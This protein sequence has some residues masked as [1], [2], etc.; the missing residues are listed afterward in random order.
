MKIKSCADCGRKPQEG[1]M[2]VL[3]LDP[4]SEWWLTLF[5][6]PH[7]CLDCADKIGKKEVKTK[8]GLEG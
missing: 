6:S 1:E 3:F 5:Y 8:N 7:Y 2:F 4:N